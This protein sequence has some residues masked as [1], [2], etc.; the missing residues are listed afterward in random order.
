MSDCLPGAHHIDH[1]SLLG[2]GEELFVMAALKVFI[3]LCVGMQ[4][5]TIAA[6]N[7]H[8]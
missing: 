4:V 8:Y 6:C 1:K 3:Q 2:P 7:P 5:N